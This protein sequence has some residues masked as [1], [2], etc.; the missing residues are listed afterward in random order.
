MVAIRDSVT[1]VDALSQS[2]SALVTAVFTRGNEPPGVNVVYVSE[3]PDAHDQYGRQLVRET[4]IVH[5]DQQPAHGMYWVETT[6]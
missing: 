4:S 2:H 1:F 3:D 6:G 5:K